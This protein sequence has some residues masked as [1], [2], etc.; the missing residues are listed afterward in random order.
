MSELSW[1][2]LLGLELKQ[3]TDPKVYVVEN[4]IDKNRIFNTVILEY[5]Q[6]WCIT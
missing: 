6:S 3:D 5:W 1:E 4:I 2:R